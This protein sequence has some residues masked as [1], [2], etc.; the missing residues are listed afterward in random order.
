M[1]KGYRVR[2]T[3][4][5]PWSQLGEF[6]LSPEILKAMGECL[7]RIFSQEALK[8]FAKRGWSI[9]DPNGGPDIGKS[10]S[11]RVKGK[12]TV[13]VLSTFW[14]MAELVQK[15]RLP[16]RM[17]WLTQEAKD[18]A[19]QKYELT[20]E[21]KKRGMSAAGRVS[22]GSRMPLVV[23]LK[24]RS[25]EVVFRTAPL[26]MQDAWVHPGIAKFT[27]A[28]RAIDKGKK[29]CLGVIRD[30]AIRILRAGDPTK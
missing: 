7:V 10:F 20:K 12:S 14:G 1:P 8:D 24:S 18:Q 5:K 6:D 13:E 15:A 2:G 9:R 17:V 3:Y 11:Y 4:G 21:E 27:F 23:P 29:E 28:R 25:G 19:P 22:K 16:H 26:K 30:E